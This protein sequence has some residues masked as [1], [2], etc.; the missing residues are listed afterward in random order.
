MDHHHEKLR[1]RAVK[2]GI[3]AAKQRHHVL[4]EREVLSLK[5]QVLPALPRVMIGLAGAAMIGSG[6]SGVPVDSNAAQAALVIG[7][8]LVVLFAAFGVRRTLSSIVDNLA[9]DA[10]GELLSSVI[11]SIA[12]AVD[13]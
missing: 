2:A 6:I 8:L 7:G 9:S 10:A 4:D 1:R 12:D 13:F 11:G 3:R 5:V